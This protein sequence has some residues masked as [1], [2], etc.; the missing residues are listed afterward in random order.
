VSDDIPEWERKLLAN[1]PA[2]QHRDAVFTNVVNINK[3]QD[4]RAYSL[5]ALVDELYEVANAPEGTRNH[6]LNNAALKLGTLVAAGGLTQLEVIQPLL[7]AAM[8]NGLPESE[9]VG[10]T[11]SG[12][13][14]GLLNPREIPNS[15][16]LLDAF[17]REYTDVTPTPS[18]ITPEQGTS[19]L[20]GHTEPLKGIEPDEADEPALPYA[21]LTWAA[22]GEVRP[23]TLPSIGERN[24]GAHILYAG[25]ING[26]YGDP[27]TAKTWFALHLAQQVLS[28]GG[29]VALI[30]ID[31][32]GENDTVDRLRKLGVSN[33]LIGDAAHFRY[34]IPET[35]A[36]L[37]ATRD[38]IIEQHPTLCIL[39]SIGELIPMLGLDS[40]SNDDI[41]RGYR[42]MLTP[43]AQE[44]T[45]VLTID[46]LAKAGKSDHGY[47]IGGI[48][49]KRIINGAYYHAEA[50]TIPAPGTVGKVRIM[51]TKDRP[52]GIREHAPQGSLGNFIIDSSASDGHVNALIANVIG[53]P[54]RPT[55][56]MERIS[57]L[58]AG[59]DGMHKTTIGKDADVTKA[60]TLN[61]A[62]L[63]LVQEEYVRTGQ[64]AG[65]TIYYHERDYRQL[66][67]ELNSLNKAD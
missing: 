5:K 45:A 16:D 54:L 58:L 7:D 18:P 50:L 46:H 25:K 1:K 65:K 21:D 24:D 39:D 53:S 28:A 48:A 56:A 64:V 49:K 42:A 59:N 32:N 27:E 4:I 63:V 37:L 60:A 43:L 2:K 52:G 29:T 31:H 20:E 55:N 17:I 57:R 12:Y 26:I 35:P 22:N 23:P 13:E 47:A 15:V 10:T 38:D 11:R 3:N 6:T 34:Y 44:H 51:V 67:E 8:G 61:Q 19:A 41:S 30:D 40:N 14:F 33:Q 9:A 62:L 36:E 66:D